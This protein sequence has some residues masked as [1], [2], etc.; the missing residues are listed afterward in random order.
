MLLA[1]LGGCATP[2][3][4]T[5][6]RY[7]APADAAGR[8]CL[9]KCEPR[10]GVCQASCTNKYQACLKD[11]E[12]TVDARYR[13]ALKHY[14]NAFQRYRWEMDR[15]QRYLSLGWVYYPPGYAPWLYT[16]WHDSFYFPPTPPRKP[17]RDELFKQVRQEKCENDCGCQ[18]VYDACFLTCGGKKIPEVQC[19]AH[20][21]KEK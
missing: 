17:M 16:P 19:I 21:P 13:D 6:Y 4:E 18:P 3:Y 9:E 10:L 8:V 2:R 20:C 7:E 15:Y 11:I 14:D 1:V 12:P 5:T